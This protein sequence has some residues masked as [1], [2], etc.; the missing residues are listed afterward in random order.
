MLRKAKL[1]DA[2]AIHSLLCGFADKGVLLNR[3]LNYIY[4]NLRDF[5]VYEKKGKIIGCCSL[6]I[7]GWNDMAEVKSLAINK[8]YQK[9]GIGRL[10]VEESFKEA[11][12]LGIKNI[13]TLTF[14]PEFF[15]KLGFKRINKSQ[16]PN[17]IW[18]DCVNCSQ[19]PNCK[20]IAL[21]HK[22]KGKI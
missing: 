4:E 11:K 9:K 3:P 14:V 17:K 16:L 12:S 7:I 15:E 5:W 22:V 8:A 6:H 2:K 13:F 18:S 19:F 1:T 10:F 20:E 21:I